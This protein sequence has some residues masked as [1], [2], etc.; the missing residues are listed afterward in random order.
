MN[1][2]LI[3]IFLCF[4][5]LY[6]CASTG[7]KVALNDRLLQSMIKYFSPKI[8]KMMTNI[9][10]GDFHIALNFYGDDVKLHFPSNF[11]S[12]FTVH[13]SN[14][15]IQVKCNGLS[16]RADGDLRTSFWLFSLYKSITIDVSNFRMDAKLKI[17]NKP[18]KEG[19]Y[20]PTLE[21]MGDPDVNASI[22]VSSS[23]LIGAVISGLANLLLPLF[24]KS[25]INLGVGEGKDQFYKILNGFEM[26]ACIDSVNGLWIDYS[27][28]SPV[29]WTSNF[30]E[31]NTYGLVYNKKK[32][33]TQKG[34]NGIALADIPYLTNMD[35]QL[36]IYVSEYS[37]NSAA[38]TFL[39]T[40]YKPLQFKLN[41]DLLNAF[42][43]GFKN[44]FKDSY[45]DVTLQS[46]GLPKIQLTNKGLL[47]KY[48]HLL[49][50]KVPSRQKPAFY[51]EIELT[52]EIDLRV[53]YGPT[54][55]ANINELSAK[56]GTIYIKDASD[57]AKDVIENSFSFIKATVIELFNAAAKNMKYKFPSVMGL[58][59]KDLK[60]E[61]KNNHIVINYNLS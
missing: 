13:L 27:L 31:L 22:H 20:K 52:L 3:L 2:H 43:P 6:I 30:I 48:P 38:K 17:V 51:T 14:N 11:M 44:N 19:G 54:I 49:T 5:P 15:V 24:K 45:G 33:E 55:Y 21:F 9:N 1:K 32:T 37:I 42:L 23:G 28:I 59:F 57:K 25:L 39:T 50:V 35:N 40:F 36:Q 18:L 60:F 46:R 7:I 16:A 12:Y 8:N 58:T 34:K 56:L 10:I 4:L 26:E 47:V 61:F 41:A 53:D 29:R